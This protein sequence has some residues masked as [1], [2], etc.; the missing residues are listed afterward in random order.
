MR[1]LF[2]VP[3]GIFALSAMICYPPFNTFA[4]DIDGPKVRSSKTKTTKKKVKC[5]S[6]NKFKATEDVEAK[7]KGLK[8]LTNYDLYVVPNKKWGN[9]RQP[10]GT[11]VS[12]DGVE[13][14]ASDTNGKFDCTTVWANPLIKGKYDIVL[15]CDQDGTYDPVDGDTVDGKSNNPGFKVR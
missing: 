2:L 5:K 12:S 1:K 15:D 4:D 9:T 8:P 13:T 6:T 11:D 7:G 10:I 14:V 3:L